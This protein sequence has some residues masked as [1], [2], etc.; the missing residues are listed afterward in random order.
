M[1]DVKVPGRWIYSSPVDLGEFSVHA[2]WDLLSLRAVHLSSSVSENAI[3]R[4][5]NRT[6]SILYP[7]LKPT[8]KSMDVSILPMMSL[9]MFFVHA[10]D[11]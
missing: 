8:L 9:T 4:N 11:F 10:F 6:G 3:I 2:D 7:C 1:S 5:R